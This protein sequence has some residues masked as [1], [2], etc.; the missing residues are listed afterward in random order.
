MSDTIGG[1]TY[2]EDFHRR[3]TALNA[4]PSQ[5]ACLGNILKSA[6]RL[7]TKTLPK[8]VRPLFIPLRYGSIKLRQREH[9]VPTI[10]G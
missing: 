2:E 6:A 7:Q 8:T 4:Q 9:D 3:D 1:P 10:S 5:T